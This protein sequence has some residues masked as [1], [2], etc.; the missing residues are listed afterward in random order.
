MDAPCRGVLSRLRSTG[1]VGSLLGQGGHMAECRGWGAA[2]KEG[3][4]DPSRVGEVGV[5]GRRSVDILSVVAMKMRACG[6]R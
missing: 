3:A 6:R 1:L 4:A 2:V 5:D